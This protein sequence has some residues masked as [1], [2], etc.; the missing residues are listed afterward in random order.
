MIYAIEVFLRCKQV[1]LI[2]HPDFKLKINK[3]ESKHLRYGYKCTI[4]NVSRRFCY[5]ESFY[6]NVDLSVNWK[7]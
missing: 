3:T 7:W 2:V 1:H 4:D 5:F 6:I